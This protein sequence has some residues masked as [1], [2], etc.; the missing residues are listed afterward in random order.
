MSGDCDVQGDCVSSAGYPNV[1]GNNGACTINVLQDSSISVGSTFNLETCCDHL[2]IGGTDVESSDA[3]PTSM[4]AG[5]SFT[6]STDGSVTREGWQICFSDS[7]D[8]GGTGDFFRM[9]GDCEIQGDCVSSMDYPNVHGNGEE[10]T[11]EMLQDATVSVGSTFNLETCCDHL[12]IGGEDV[13][14]SDAVPTSLSAG[15]EFTWS[16]DGSVTREGWQL[17]FSPADGSNHFVLKT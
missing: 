15:D 9:S 11:I 4:N 1:H 16:T 14:S 17:C 13:E 6:W 2:M 12:M 10:C 7:D 8:T 5:D 3:V